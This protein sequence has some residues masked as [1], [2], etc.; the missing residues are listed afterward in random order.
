L[1]GYRLSACALTALGVLATPRL[2]AQRT[3][4]STLRRVDS[5]EVVRIRTSDGRLRQ[6]RLSGAAPSE[7]ILESGKLHTDGRIDS[8]WV[9]DN[10]TGTGAIVGA[11]AVGVPSV[12]VWY[13]LCKLGREGGCEGRD[14]LAVATASALTAGAGAALGALIGSGISRWRLRYARPRVS[15]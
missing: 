6:G 12:Y 5:G 4:D 14:L 11:L 9:R 13:E 15:Q 10:A 2:A 7:L 1:I 8:L 3:P